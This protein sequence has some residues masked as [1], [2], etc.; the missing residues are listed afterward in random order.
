[1]KKLQ[2]NQRQFRGGYVPD[3]PIDEWNRSYRTE[4]SSPSTSRN[5][6]GI[7]NGSGTQSRSGLSVMQSYRKASSANKRKASR[8]R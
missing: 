1:M 3:Q 2:V 5:H 8:G 4:P 6:R 7:M